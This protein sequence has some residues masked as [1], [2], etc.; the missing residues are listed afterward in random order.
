MRTDF[1][2]LMISHGRSGSSAVRG[3]LNL[4]PDINM[5]FEENLMILQDTNKKVWTGDDHFSFDHSLAE[6]FLSEDY[7]GNKIILG[8][9]FVSAERIAECVERKVVIVNK[10]FSNIKILLLSRNKEDTIASIAERKP[11]TLEWAR[12]NWETN[13]Y[14]MKKLKEIFS[15]NHKSFDF[16]EFVQEESVR[17]SVFDYLELPYSKDWNRQKVE[18]GAYGDNFLSL[19]NLK[20][21][22]K[23]P[24][25]KPVLGDDGDF[26]VQTKPKV[27]KKI[28]KSAKMV[29]LTKSKVSKKDK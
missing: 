13:E 8:P 18:T 14:Q 2:I 10:V 24:I 15:H 16:Y 11:D 7:N 19:D 21:F 12:E 3:F 20:H 27:I 26:Q 28:V 25:S 22:T 6:R 4:S 17:K 23:K 5:A 1:F 29:K 9:H